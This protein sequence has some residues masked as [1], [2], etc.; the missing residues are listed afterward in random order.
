[1]NSALNVLSVCYMPTLL[2]RDVSEELDAE[3]AALAERNRRSKEKQ[4]LFL[5]QTGIRRIRTH[6]EVMEDVNRTVAKI[7]GKVTLEEILKFTE[8]GH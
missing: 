6:E 3:L 5:I 8:A 7:K 2:I 1:L 4:A